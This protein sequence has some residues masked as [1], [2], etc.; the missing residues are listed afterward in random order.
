MDKGNFSVEIKQDE[1][2]RQDFDSYIDE[3][4]RKYHVPYGI[5]KRAVFSNL[6]KEEL[7]DIPHAARLQYRLMLLDPVIKAKVDFTKQR[8]IVVYNPR[9]AN[10]IKEKIS[11]DELVGILAKEGIHT[12]PAHTEEADYDYYK[13]FYS[14]TYNPQRIRERPPYG[15]SPEEW[16]GMKGEYENKMQKL[17][18][19]KR[20]KFKEWQDSYLEAN[21]EIAQKV[22]PDFKPKVVKRSFLTKIFGK[23]KRREK[24]KGFWFHGV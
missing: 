14:Y 15:Y 2:K 13:D 23:G 22:V 12:D 17:E 18:V 19:E 20:Q 8:I 1:S 3:D 16:G 5:V 6:K 11:Q 9:T 24:D 10:N 4:G 7:I 21:P